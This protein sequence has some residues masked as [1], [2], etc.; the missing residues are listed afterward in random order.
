MKSTVES[1]SAGPST[2]MTFDAFKPATPLWASLSVEAMSQMD[3][4]RVVTS[5]DV[6]HLL[7]L[8][9][10]FRNVLS[11]RHVVLR[12]LP[13]PFLIGP[14]PWCTHCLAAAREYVVQDLH[15]CV[16]LPLLI[17]SLSALVPAAL[18]LCPVCHYLVDHPPPPFPFLLFHSSL[19]D[20]EGSTAHAHAH[21]ASPHTA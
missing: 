3:T 5:V 6:L 8:S 12:W 1:D 13:C 17:I 2:G 10:S 16:P 15:V 18:R 4:A 11:I 14:F 20:E 7:S 9:V 21:D 19:W